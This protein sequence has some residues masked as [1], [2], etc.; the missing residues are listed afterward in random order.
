MKNLTLRNNCKHLVRS[1]SGLKSLWQIGLLLLLSGCQTALTPANTVQAVARI[2]APVLEEIS[3]I[4]RSTRSE[5]LLWVINDS[6]NSNQ[7]HTLT[8]SS[9]ELLAS[10]SIVGITNVDWEDLATFELDGQHWLLIADV[11]DNRASR[12]YGHLYLL[13]EPELS[14]SSA[15]AEAISIS[16]ET[17]FSF[18]DGARDVEAVAV[19]V[20]RREVMLI[21]KRDTPPGV[22]T[23]PLQLQT[24]SRPLL[25]QRIADVGGLLPEN[26]MDRLRFGRYSPH[27]AQPT[28]LDIHQPR[29][30]GQSVSAVLLT[31]KH[32]Y[33][34]QRQAGADWRHAW[35]NP[36]VID[37]PPMPQTEA[38]TFSHSGC[39]LWVTT[40]QLP[41]PL[42]RIDSGLC[43]ETGQ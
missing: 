3:G 13:P 18:A 31:Y 16:A 5:A 17:V 22:Y 34:F 9:G 2:D 21:S 41:A 30:S 43:D 32:A 24:S 7:I 39:S 27:V 33:L 25:A 10:I 40:E 1:R 42:H 23:L 14:G 37:V 19:D 8:A 26:G 20:A 29:Q 11:G 4:A 6:G 12:R 28:A 36:A 38:L 35:Q 15:A